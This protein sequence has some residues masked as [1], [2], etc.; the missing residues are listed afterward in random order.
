M[1]TIGPCIT[2]SLT[3][4][5]N[6]PTP[7][8]Q[9][10][11][12]SLPEDE[13]ELEKTRLLFQ[14][15]GLAQTI[16]VINGGV[17]L[18]I[19]GGL[20]P[21]LWAVGWLLLAIAVSASRYGL[22]RRFSRRAPP[23]AEAFLWRRRAVAGALVAGLVWSGGVTAIMIAE[24]ETVRLFAALVMCGMVA[25]AVPIL[26]SVP[27]AF[28]A[29]TTPVMLA[30]VATAV[31]DNHGPRDWM[32]AL[33]ALLFLFA[34]VK[35][36]RYFHDS[37][38]RSIHLALHMRRMA[39]QLDLA[40]QGAEA[41]STAKSRFLA[42]MS[43]EIRTP[44][45]GILGMA[46]ILLAPRMEDAERR[47]CAHTIL[48]SGQSL[49]R[50]LNDILDLSKVEAGKL[51]LRPT[52]FDPAQLIAE[53]AS[54]FAEP[55]H[56]K[57]LAMDTAW[58]GP[59][60]CHYRADA[61]RLRQMLTNFVNNAIK[62]TFH[63]SIR[64]EA[65]ELARRGD[66]ALLEFA[67]ADTGIG[68]PEDKRSLL[69]QPFSQVDGSDTRQFGGSGLGLSIVSNLAR[70]MEGEVGVD[71]EEGKGSRF[72]FRVLA[73]VQPAAEAQP[74]VPAADFAAGLAGRRVLLVEDNGI[75][76][77]VIKTMLEKQ[78][79]GVS[80]ADDGQAA[81]DLLAGGLRPDL[82]L[83]DC[84]MPVM[85]GFEATVRIRGWEQALGLPR[86]PIV[87]LTAG[88]FEDDRHR[89]LEAG[90]DDYLAKPVNLPELLSTLA[91]WL[92]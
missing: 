87:A 78:G 57:G 51:E 73:G 25:G 21:P 67:V 65:R 18:F 22:A 81:L 8:A 44:M 4:A 35:S 17:L 10:P 85:D 9:A 43:H 40:R 68:I 16:T 7:D 29:Y 38:D 45:N 69:F 55:V 61:S 54:L 37:L 77:V 53:I 24:P 34:L 82:I 12:D 59:A 84:Q 1:A 32:L 75:N 41:A 72:W 47:D 49:L 89:C 26:S 3:P 15:A 79:M 91:K 30:M 46:Q 88:A 14:N 52:D 23:P 27:A 36:A 60:D 80:S 11:G 2:L 28:R 42:A 71:S 39:E 86:L 76:R 50:L 33:I 63:G 83:M 66:Q 48:S 64:I 31:I 74:T 5:Q 90:M 56:E 92:A 19:L 62:F 70:L 20:S 58:S 6:L 13:V